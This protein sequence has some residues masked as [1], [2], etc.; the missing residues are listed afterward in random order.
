MPLYGIVL[1][2]C[3]SQRFPP[4][5]RRLEVNELPGQKI[6]KDTDYFCQTF[7]YYLF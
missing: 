6:I 3:V 4:K 5:A 2:N 7:G 1:M